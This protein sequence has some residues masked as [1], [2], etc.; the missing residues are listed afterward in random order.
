MSSLYQQ[1]CFLAPSE[2]GFRND[3]KHDETGEWKIEALTKEIKSIQD[4][5]FEK[6][7]SAE[8]TSLG[9]RFVEKKVIFVAAGSAAAKQGIQAGVRFVKI[10]GKSV[11]NSTSAINAML[12]LILRK[13]KSFSVTLRPPTARERH[14]DSGKPLTKPSHSSSKI[15]TSPKLHLNGSASQG[16][17]G[18]SRSEVDTKSAASETQVTEEI[19]KLKNS[20]SGLQKKLD[21]ERKLRENERQQGDIW[22]QLMN[23]QI[24]EL[25]TAHKV[26]E[27]ELKQSNAKIARLSESL[28]KTNQESARLKERLSKTSDELENTK[29][30][31]DDSNQKK[32]RAEK[33]KSEIKTKY[34]ST[35]KELEEITK[36]F[37][38]G[39][40]LMLSAH[41]K[42]EELE[43]K[44]KEAEDSKLKRLLQRKDEEITRL[45]RQVEDLV[46]IGGVGAS[47][48][49]R[50]PSK[51]ELGRHR[52][53]F[54]SDNSFKID[55]ADI[56]DMDLKELY[57][58]VDTD[59][60]THGTIVLLVSHCAGQVAK[61]QQDRL[62]HLFA[63]LGYKFEEVDGAM[64]KSLRV[65]LCE[66]SGIGTYPQVFMKSGEG[67]N[68]GY[69]FIGDSQRV[70]DMN[71]VGKIHQIFRGCAR[72]KPSA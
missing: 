10:D 54:G 28:D 55:S 24:Q 51:G 62:R 57:A 20:V 1:L 13:S 39:Q 35:K 23:S 36:I 5:V 65:V 33:E 58:K 61:G 66:K 59:I 15:S 48:Q 52:N 68:A 47:S 12:R 45:K 71:E 25:E 21:T 29:K 46:R 8:T 49:A 4:S 69:V 9:V 56:E 40:Q 50:D 44:L 34:D 26:K 22:K 41:K 18:S 37:N 30:A 11:P 38:N 60:G 67:D 6:V 16:S 63:A 2:K 64:N 14:R 31:Y 7:F 42:I 19:I 27:E 70:F 3:W 17:G 43:A 53:G 72:N 32:Q